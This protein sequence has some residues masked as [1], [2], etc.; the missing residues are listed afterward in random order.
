MKKNVIRISFDSYASMDDLN[1]EDSLLL[2]EA[3]KATKYA[4]APYSRFKVGAAARLKNGEIIRGTNQENA[5][6]PAGICAERTLISAVASRFPGEPIIT[7]AISYRAR[8]GDSRKPIAPCG[9]CRQV[10][11]EYEERTQQPMRIILSGQEGPVFILSSVSELLPMA[12]TSKD[13]D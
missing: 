6:F 13:L 3:R 9:I 12:F 11:K 7:M 2:K 4:Y 8:G 1:E 10:M 5:S